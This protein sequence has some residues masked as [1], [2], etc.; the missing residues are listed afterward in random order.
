MSSS[1]KTLAAALL[2]LCVVLP[3][4]AAD[5]RPPTCAKPVWPREAIRYELEGATTLY[6]RLDEEG[7]ITRTE[8][9]RSS[10]WDLL[11]QAAVQSLKACTFPSDLGKKSA[12]IMLPV[13]YVWSL[14][15][16]E[17]VNLALVEGSC[18]ASDR[19]SRFA[20]FDKGVTGPDG[21]LV[22]MLVARDGVPFGIKVEARDADPGLVGAV[23]E[24]VQTCRFA[25]PADAKLAPTDT[26]TGRVLLK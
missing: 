4:A 17:R 3:A 22:R 25:R 5:I 10:R 16:P 9:F 19:F 14:D 23:T 24:Y 21:V 15:G 8:V 7:R 11:D 26:V 20:P 1:S 12:G 2:S 18:P 13:Q 6:F